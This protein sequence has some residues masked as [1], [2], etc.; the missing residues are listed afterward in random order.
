MGG[1]KDFLLAVIGSKNKT[2]LAFC[3]CF[4]L[5]TSIFSIIEISR[6]T[7]FY[8]YILIFVLLFFIIIFFEKKVVRI[9]LLIGLFFILGICRLLYSLPIIDNNFIS[10]YNG[11]KQIVTGVIS[12]EPNKKVGWHEYELAVN[13]LENKNGVEKQIFGKVLFRTPSY[14]EFFYGDKIQFECDLKAPKNTDEFNYQKFLA[15]K[16]IYSICYPGEIK[17]IAKNQN[18]KIMSGIFSFKRQL[19]DLTQKLWNEPQ[20]TLAAGILYGERSGFD[21]ELKNNFSKSGITHIVA[22]SGYNITIIVFILMN[23][24]IWGGLYRRQAFWICLILIFLFVIFTGASASAARAGLMGSLL[25]FAQQLGRKSDIFK[26]LVYAAV[27][28]SFIN[29]LILIWDV[30]FQLS[31]LATIGLIYLTPLL[32]KYFIKP[33]KFLMESKKRNK[34]KDFIN[35][36]MKEFL[37]PTLAATIFTLPLISY[38]FGYFSIL[39]ILA[40]VLV[41]WLIPFLMLFSFVSISLAIIF[42]PLGQVLAWI[43]N[44]GLSYVIMIAEKIGNIPWVSLNYKSPLV[45]CLIIYGWL[46]YWIISKN[47][48]QI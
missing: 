10:F 8:F 6:T 17:V 4:I 41:I 32:E 47:N 14:P 16:N 38:S 40:N 2:L 45:V 29:P 33:P 3:F 46:F 15:L 12:D 28:L 30:G 43:T 44:L 11:Q 42:Y 48:H 35:E 13:L 18:S 36:L 25:L 19:N 22:V 9:F 24:L 27:L 1:V 23:I 20:S 7:L 5:A 39:S 31:F 34:T 21:D 26:L 37:I